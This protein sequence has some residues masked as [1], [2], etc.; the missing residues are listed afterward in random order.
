MPPPFDEKLA[1]ELSSIS[2]KLDAMYGSGKHCYEDGTCY[3]LGEFELIMDNSR[4]SHLFLKA[5]TGGLEIGK[6]MKPKYM[7]CQQKSF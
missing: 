4:N 6:P 3:N 1:G 5:W 7:I 2:T